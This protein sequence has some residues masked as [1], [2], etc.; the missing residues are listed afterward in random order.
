[1]TNL[2]ITLNNKKLK[3]NLSNSRSKRLSRYI[4]NYVISRD[5]WQMAE[6]V[7]ENMFNARNV[8]FHDPKFP[9][10]DLIVKKNNDLLNVKSS[11]QKT[12]KSAIYS[13]LRGKNPKI[14]FLTSLINYIMRSTNS[15]KAG[16]V[17]I[18]SKIIKSLA[19]QNFDQNLKD[20]LLNT[21]NQTHNTNLKNFYRIP[22][23]KENVSLCFV[24]NPTHLNLNE[25]LFCSLTVSKT[26]NQTLKE[27]FDKTL[28]DIKEKNINIYDMIFHIFDERC[29][30]SNRYILR[31]H[32]DTKDVKRI[33]KVFGLYGQ[34]SNLKNDVINQIRDM[35]GIEDLRKLKKQLKTKIK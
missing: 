10:I 14:K 15:V 34:M 6:N 17:M 19:T 21:Y 35:G 33:N 20:F 27:L 3:T 7:I 1:M 28:T 25:T 11:R 13:S 5:G 29:D 2:S 23:L 31:T 9:F 30:F 26:K 4:Y 16:D 22:T 32:F 12:L 24:Y 8:N 18:G